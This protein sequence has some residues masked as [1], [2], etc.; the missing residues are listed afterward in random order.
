[1][2]L[3]ISPALAYKPPVGP[4]W[5]ELLDKYLKNEHKNYVYEEKLDGSRY[6]GHIHNIGITFTSRRISDVT[7]RFAEYTGGKLEHLNVTVP[8]HDKTI[9]DGELM[10]TSAA[11][12]KEG[13]YQVFD[14]LFFKGQDLRD[15]PLRERLPY[16]KIAVQDIKALYPDV[17]IHEVETIPILDAN[18]VRLAYEQCVNNGGEGFVLKNLDSPYL[19]GARSRDMW[20]KWKRYETYD[21]I[22]NGFEVSD[23]DKYGPNGL[24]TFRHL[25]GY[26]YDSEGNLSLVTNIPATSWT[27]EEHKELK[28]AGLGSLDGRIAE[29]GAMERASKGVK[30]RHPRF[31]RWRTDKNAKD[32]K[33]G[34]GHD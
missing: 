17:D 28:A 11:A 33:I 18:L 23:S 15:L 10:A 19:T 1:M 14:I 25:Y 20:L 13:S 24:D 16:R 6:L 31:I 7:H 32:C 4:K 2:T 5:Q 30:L 21:V 29:V 8:L 12:M 26:Q 22:I 3:Q 27:D 34:E 9:L